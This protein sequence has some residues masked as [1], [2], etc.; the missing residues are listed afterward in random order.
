MLDEESRV[1]CEEDSVTC[2]IDVLN[3]I[4]IGTGMPQLG[5][6]NEKVENDKI[7]HGYLMQ[8]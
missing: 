4:C 2:L 6:T 5:N 1:M 7:L 8:G 3:I